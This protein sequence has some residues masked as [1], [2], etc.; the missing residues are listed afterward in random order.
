MLKRIKKLDVSGVAVGDIVL[1]LFF[2][3][4]AENFLNGYNFILILRNSCTLLVASIGMTLAILVSQIDLSVGSVVSMS[5]V[6]VAIL[7]NAGCPL[8]LTIL[9]TLAMGALV[10]LINGILISK[11]K[12]DFWVVTFSTM[13]IMAGLALV[14]AD[15]ATVS[16]QN[17]VLDFIGNGK[18]LGVYTVIW[19]TALVCA[20]M[21]LVLKK[22]KFGYNVY[23]I[24]G[25]ATVAGVSGVKVVKNRTMVYVLSGIFSAI[26]GIMIAG[27]TNSGSP[28]VG[29]EY[30]FSAMAAVVIGGTS[31]DGGKGGI[32]GT[33][34]GTL[35]LKILA[36]GLSLMGIPSTWQKA[37]IGIVILVLIITDVVS[38]KRKNIKGLRRVYQDVD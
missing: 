14:I 3:V 32:V 23:S 6:M 2:C 11:F 17:E 36:S 20:I 31:F 22:T 30:T 26:S 34:C 1:F 15:G 37:T 33:I 8:I 19:I 9:A 27:M 29:N 38:E 16:T 25:S 4:A 18:I 10:G 5:A 13:S 35:L 28:T 7:N 21:I 12:L 24:G